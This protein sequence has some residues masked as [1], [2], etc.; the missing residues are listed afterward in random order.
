MCFSELSVQTSISN[1]FHDIALTKLKVNAFLKIFFAYEE[2][3]NNRAADQNY[4]VQRFEKNFNDIEKSWK[5]TVQNLSREIWGCVSEEEKGKY[6]DDNSSMT[7]EKIIWRIIVYVFSKIVT[8]LTRFRNAINECSSLSKI[9]SWSADPTVTLRG[10]QRF[11]LYDRDLENIGPLGSEVKS[12]KNQCTQN[13]TDLKIGR[14]SG[15]VTDCFEIPKPNQSFL[16][17]LFRAKPKVEVCVSVSNFCYKNI[18]TH[19]VS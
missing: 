18:Y 6:F 10:F 14:C 15:F 9:N 5:E 17:K 4:L 12:I 13:C 19:E 1:I 7:H 8:I 16:Q 2:K 11:L 3:F